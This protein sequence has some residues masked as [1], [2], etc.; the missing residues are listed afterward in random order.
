[1]RRLLKNDKEDFVSHAF[2]CLTSLH[3]HIRDIRLKDV[4]LPCFT[5][6]HVQLLN[7][8]ILPSVD[9]QDLWRT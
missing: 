5:V 6:F 8:S 9:E 7:I 1:M 4:H 2:Q 3:C